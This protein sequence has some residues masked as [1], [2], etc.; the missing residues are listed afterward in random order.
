MAWIYSIMDT[1][2]PD[3]MIVRDNFEVLPHERLRELNATGAIGVAVERLD[4]GYYGFKDYVTP[5][6]ME[7]MRVMREN[8]FYGPCIAALVRSW[9]LK[10]EFNDFVMRV[11]EV[12]LQR[13]WMMDVT[14]RQL[15][16]TVQFHLKMSLVHQFDEPQ[17]EELRLNRMIGIFYMLIFGLILA[18]VVFVLEVVHSKLAKG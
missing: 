9:Y 17:P 18:M 5:K 3:L 7:K 16:P 13:Y 8:I 11:D 10:D 1:D 15:D 6:T 14:F 2:N 4:Y 12:G